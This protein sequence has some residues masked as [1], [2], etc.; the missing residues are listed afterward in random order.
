MYVLYYDCSWKLSYFL[1][2]FLTKWFLH[3][4]SENW[5]HFQSLLLALAFEQIEHIPLRH[6]CSGFQ[7]ISIPLMALRKCLSMFSLSAL[8]LIYSL[9]HFFSHGKQIRMCS[10]ILILL[11]IG[12]LQRPQC[13]CIYTINSN[14]TEEYFQR[15]AL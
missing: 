10:V 7:V 1:R 6:S 5:Q 4:N 8:I 15:P 9:K 13:K 2:I 11:P 12:I 3:T 14:Q